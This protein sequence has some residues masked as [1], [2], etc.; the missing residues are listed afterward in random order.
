MPQSEQLCIVF[1]P[2]LVVILTAAEQKKGAPLSEA[3]VLEIRDNAACISL[4]V[5]VAQAMDDSRGYPDISAE[6]CWHE[7]Q[8]LRAEVRP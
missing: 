7:W 5:E 8:Q 2:A 6:N 4:P 1:V 3:Q